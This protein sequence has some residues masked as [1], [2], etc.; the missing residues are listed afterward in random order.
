MSLKINDLLHIP[1]SDIEK[2]KIKF[3]QLFCES[4]NGFLIRFPPDSNKCS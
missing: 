1:Q 3:N 4:K 2:V